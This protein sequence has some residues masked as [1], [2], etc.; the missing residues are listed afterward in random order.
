MKKILSFIAIFVVSLLF[1]KNVSALDPACTQ[2]EQLRLRQLASA[3]DVTYE[4]YEDKDQ[5]ENFRGYKV[6]INNF[7]SAFYVY[8]SE[9]G[10]YFIYD[11]D[12]VSTGLGFVGGVYNLPFYASDDSVCKGY[13]ILTK[14]VNLVPYNLYSEDPLC[15]GYEKFELCKKFTPI[16]VYSYDDFKLR[17]NAY[18]KS[19][20]NDKPDDPTDK[21]TEEPETIWDN[22]SDFLANNY[23]I[24]LITIIIAGTAGIIVIQVRKRRSIL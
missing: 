2:E 21:P 16:Q 15:K 1:C 19:L 4:F 10:A 17:L 24:I 18:I 5:G 11:G 9:T 20:E 7:N 23:M 8:D 14:Q 3:T 6:N 22:I 13:L 12:L